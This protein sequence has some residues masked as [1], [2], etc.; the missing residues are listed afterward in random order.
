MANKGIHAMEVALR[1]FIAGPPHRFPSAGRPWFLS[2]QVSAEW[3][4]AVA[5]AID[6]IVGGLFGDQ[7]I[8]SVAFLLPGG[9]HA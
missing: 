3:I 7:D 8:V 5:S 9:S 2:S 6:P 4:D 1:E